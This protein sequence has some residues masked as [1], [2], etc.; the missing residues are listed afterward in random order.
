MFNRLLFLLI[1][2]WILAACGQYAEIPIKEEGSSERGALLFAEG[3]GDDSP[4]CSSC[5]KISAEVYGFSIGPILQDISTTAATRIEGLTAEEYLRQSILE[6]ESFRVPG[7]RA[8]MFPDY[9]NHLTEQD[10][11][12]LIAYLLTL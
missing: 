7:A 8:T 1:L 12:D 9:A 10:V 11:S 5:H 4:A 6:P 3:K 2:T